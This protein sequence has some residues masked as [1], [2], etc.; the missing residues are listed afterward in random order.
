MMNK[1]N[2]SEKQLE[3]IHDGKMAGIAFDHFS[4]Y[5]DAKKQE[6]IN[7]LVMQYKAGNFEHVKYTGNIAAY[8][9][10]NDIQHSLRK[11]IKSG[12]NEKGVIHEPS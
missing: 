3:K 6:L 8:S 9:A 7:D 1:I 10:I 2:I 12:N 5:L 11:K 4:H